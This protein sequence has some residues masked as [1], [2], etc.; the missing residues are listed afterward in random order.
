MQ[1]SCM[2]SQVKTHKF[3][4]VASITENFLSAQTLV[5]NYPINP[6]KFLEVW[7][8]VPAARLPAVQIYGL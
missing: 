7:I 1:V 8:G 6:I 5:L 2:L 3:S 4:C